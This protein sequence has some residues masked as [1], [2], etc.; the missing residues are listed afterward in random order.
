MCY[1]VGRQRIDMGGG[2]VMKD[3]NI[4]SIQTKEPK[5][6]TSIPLIIQ[7]IKFEWALS[8]SCLLS[9][10]PTLWDV[11][12]CICLLEV[13]KH[14]REGASL[15]TSH[16]YLSIQYSVQFPYY[17]CSQPSHQPVDLS[18]ILLEFCALLLQLDILSF[19]FYLQPS[20][21]LLRYT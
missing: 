3:H 10:F 9:A 7:D 4:M 2:G 5:V 14:R 1:D 13:I 17:Q 6:F 18:S 11:T 16:D 12:L 15:G 8:L 19:N 20:S 21:V